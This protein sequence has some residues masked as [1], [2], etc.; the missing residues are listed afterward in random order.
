[1]FGLDGALKK[2]GIGT[3]GTNMGPKYVPRVLNE[4]CNATALTLTA[5]PYKSDK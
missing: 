4:I 2:P 5:T 3:L 1:M